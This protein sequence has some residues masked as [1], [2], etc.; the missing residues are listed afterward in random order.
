METFN[1][2]GKVVLITG[3]SSGIGYAQAE[4]LLNKKALV[5]GID[6][7]EEGLSILQ[8]K[9]QNF[10]Y[11][12]CSVV[13]KHRLTSIV[14]ETI[15]TY[16]KIDILLNT[17]GILD[18]Y[19]P[20]LD[21]SEALWDT[22]MDT[23]IKGIYLVTN[24]VLPYMLAQKKGVI[25]N[26][27]SIAGFISGG[28]GAAYTA[29]KHAVIGYTKQLSYDYS[30]MGI[31]INAVAPGAIRTKMNEADFKGDAANAKWVAAETPAGRWADPKEV[32]DLTL[33]LVSDR[34]SYIHGT[35]VPIDGGWLNK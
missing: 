11:Y 5:I 1:F 9:Y 18:G 17:A 34:A 25:L 32:A 24:E 27:A 19:A 10:T 31:R 29:S 26:M 33:F 21:T 28:G 35:V 15:T 2:T 22:I 7:K 16:K 4:A 13:D 23:N 14:E 30:R 12:L 6:I 20:S 8:Q 3:A